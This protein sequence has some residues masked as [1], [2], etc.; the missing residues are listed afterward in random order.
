MGGHTNRPPNVS[1]LSYIFEAFLYFRI[2][3][4]KFL[5]F[6]YF[7]KD[8]PALVHWKNCNLVVFTFVL[9]I[10]ILELI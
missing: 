9:M 7:C 3:L 2:F 10:D 5:S 8:L 6:L 4:L 1:I